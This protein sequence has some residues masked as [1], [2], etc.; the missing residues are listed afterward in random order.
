MGVCND[1][2]K[3]VITT[4][5]KIIPSDLSKKIDNSLKHKNDSIIKHNRF[6]AKQRI[7]NEISQ[8]LS[9]CKHNS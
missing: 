9:K 8:L 7:K 1:D 6:L 4:E 5:P 3:L 2:S